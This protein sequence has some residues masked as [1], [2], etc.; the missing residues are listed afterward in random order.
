MKTK[1]ETRD[2]FAAAALQ[3]FMKWALDQPHFETYDSAAKAAAGY[4]KSAFM[5][6]D[7]MMSER[8]K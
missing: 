4:A 7:A 8:D 6:A 5:I 2:E 3:A 1:E